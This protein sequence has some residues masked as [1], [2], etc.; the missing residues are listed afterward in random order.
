MVTL[1][2]SAAQR[3]SVIRVD[4]AAKLGLGPEVEKES[5]LN[6]A[7]AQIVQKLGL[8]RTVEG[9]GD[10]DLD[11][12]AV[13]HQEIGPKQSDPCSSKEYVEWSLPQIRNAAL[14][15]GD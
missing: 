5:D 4:E 8:V 14:V 12:Y 1:S 15:Q 10:L 9:V 7:G 2:R 13:I 3:F 11:N 6:R